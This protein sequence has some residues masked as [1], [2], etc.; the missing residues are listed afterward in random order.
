MGMRLRRSAAEADRPIYRR[1]IP[2]AFAILLAGVGGCRS[3][4]GIDDC[5][6]GPPV[7]DEPRPLVRTTLVRNQFSE[8]EIE[9]ALRTSAP[10]AYLL[11]TPVTV[12]YHA[13]RL[14][15]ASA[16]FTDLD[17]ESSQL[18]GRWGSVM[19]SAL[20][21]EDIQK[22]FV[23]IGPETFFHPTPFGLMIRTTADGG[24]ASRFASTHPGA[25]LS[26]LADLGT[27]SDQDI[28]LSSNPWVPTVRD[29]VGDC[30][31]RIHPAIESE[32]SASALSRYVSGPDWSDRF[33]KPTGKNQMV[34]WLVERPFGH[35]SCH[36]CHIPYALA[37]LFQDKSISTESHDRIALRLDS[38]NRQL[39][40]M[41]ASDGSWGSDWS[42]Q[43]RAGDLS[44]KFTWGSQAVD[45]LSVTGHHLGWQS[46]LDSDHRLSEERLAL[47]VR[48]VLRQIELVRPEINADW[49]RYGTLTHAAS[50]ILSSTGTTDLSQRFPHLLR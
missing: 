35:G 19:R 30:A 20:F 22:T 44:E 2:A 18:K 40:R 36:G 29:V 45:R 38:Y 27:P 28:R 24:F 11:K 16:N 23:S 39:K 6:D 13:L 26:V 25:Y 14:W 3:G 17:F 42:D 9:R 48:F 33:G 15:G 41:Q 50:A 32:W 8:D 47:G 46:L 10:P 5:I 1:D 21:S 4:E 7:R 31:A 12:L 37:V 43:N 34:R 49:H